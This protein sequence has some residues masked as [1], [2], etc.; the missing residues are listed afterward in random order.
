MAYVGNTK[1]QLNDDL[2]FNI[3][4]QA[5]GTRFSGPLYMEIFNEPVAVFNSDILPQP[6]S[7][8]SGNFIPMA[9]SQLVPIA[10]QL[11]PLF[12][13]YGYPHIDSVRRK[14]TWYVYQA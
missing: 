2:P 4:W 11:L 12:N 6:G 9:N 7:V 1:P 3:N 10:P 8:A 5:I 13:Y 14:L